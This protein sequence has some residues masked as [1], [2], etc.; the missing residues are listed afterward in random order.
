MSGVILF[1]QQ[2]RGDVWR[3]EAAEYQGR[4]FANIRKWYEKDGEWRPTRQGLTMP[5]ERLPELAQALMAYS[6]H[7]CGGAADASS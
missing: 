7:D 3:F 5:L 4:R 2:Y 6:D 1:E